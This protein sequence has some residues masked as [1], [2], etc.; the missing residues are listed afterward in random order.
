[1]G[2]GL[3]ER[4]EGGRRVE[5]NR[6]DSPFLAL[7]SFSVLLVWINS[8]YH[9]LLLPYR[10]LTHSDGRI[11]ERRRG[12]REIADDEDLTDDEEGGGGWME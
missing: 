2:G 5:T 12:A 11:W 10:I 6:T 9:T 7:F 3:V 8:G 1:M 4:R